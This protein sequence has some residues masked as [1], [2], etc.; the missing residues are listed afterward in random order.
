MEMRMGVCELP[1]YRWEQG[2]N[3]QRRCLLGSLARKPKV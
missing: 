3:A 1:K 2:L